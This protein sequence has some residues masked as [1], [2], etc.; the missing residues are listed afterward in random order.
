MSSVNLQKLISKL[1]IE[2]NAGI[3]AELVKL[4][5]NNDSLMAG[6]CFISA[7]FILVY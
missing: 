3:N 2:L 4:K 5:L 6:C 1:R 7:E